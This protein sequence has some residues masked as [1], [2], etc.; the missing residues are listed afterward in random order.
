MSS[1][2][3]QPLKQAKLPFALSKRTASTPANVKAK[4]SKSTKASRAQR[5]VSS[6]SSSANEVDIE[7]VHLTSDEEAPEEYK[8]SEERPTTTSQVLSSAKSSTN[9]AAPKPETLPLP[10]DKQEKISPAPQERL[11]LK[12]KDPR[13]NDH[14]AVVREK[15]NYTKP[16]K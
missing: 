16:S 1:K 13:W 5:S 14:Y 11:E 12:E 2:T 7:D 4:T 3:S 15:M 9:K 6:S 10:K 8:K